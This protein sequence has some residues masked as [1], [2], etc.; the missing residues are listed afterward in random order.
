MREKAKVPC[1]EKK[2]RISACEGL[3]SHHVVAGAVKLTMQVAG[4]KNL[5]QYLM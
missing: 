4:V 2:L 1:K 3:S 5:Q